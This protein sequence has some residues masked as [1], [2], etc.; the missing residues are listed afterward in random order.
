[1]L[2]GSLAP[3]N[4]PEFQ[5]QDFQLLYLLVGTIQDVLNSTPFLYFKATFLPQLS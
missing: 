5:I 1:M 2:Y 3:E 4:E